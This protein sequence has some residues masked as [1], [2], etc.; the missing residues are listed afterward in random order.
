MRGRR[1]R[2]RDFVALLAERGQAL[3]DDRVRLVEEATA[4]PGRRHVAGLL[5]ACGHARNR[6]EAFHRFL[7]PIARL[8]RSKELVPIEEAIRL[9]HAADGVASLAH[10]PP[11]LGD[12]AFGSLRA[13]GLDA[14][15]AVYPWGRNSPAV[16]LREV[17]GRLGLAVSGGSDCHG[18]DPAHRR[19]GSHA[20]TS[21]EF[22]ALR[23]RAACAAR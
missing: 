11:D 3:P 22:D 19:I 14:V 5:V 16:R 20:L 13:A 12:E 1:G 6:T 17:A 9:V 8:V 18:P 2:F 4:S 10:P 15:E 23:D 7:N 21:D